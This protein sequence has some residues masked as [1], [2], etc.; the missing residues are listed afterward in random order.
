VLTPFPISNLIPGGYLEFQ[1]SELLPFSEDDSL[2]NSS[3][4]AYSNAFQS[5][6][7]AI[8]CRFD[9]SP[10]EMVGWM[11]DAGFVDVEVKKYRVPI[12]PW[13][14]DPKFKEMGTVIAV[15]SSTGFEAYGLALFTRVLGMPMEEARK[16]IDGAY[17]DITGKRVHAVHWFF[18]VYGRKPTEKEDEKKRSK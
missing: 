13:P 17:K 7:T 6:G 3:Y 15:A 12:G 14:K 10:Q 16:L 8:G 2:T 9:I 11:Q 18:C 1:E 5:A 4:L